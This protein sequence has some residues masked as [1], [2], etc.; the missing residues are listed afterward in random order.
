MYQI[1]Q[2]LSESDKWF[3]FEITLASHLLELVQGQ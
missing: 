2:S 3:H 1:S